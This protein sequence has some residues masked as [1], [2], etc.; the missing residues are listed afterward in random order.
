MNKS[1]GLCVDN[2]AA[3]TIEIVNRYAS[4]SPVPICWPCLKDRLDR[5][6]SDLYPDESNSF[7]HVIKFTVTT[8]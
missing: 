7:G 5:L 2:G 4:T 8:P 1:C 3:H 6:A